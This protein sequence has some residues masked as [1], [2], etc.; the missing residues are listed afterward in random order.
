M[1]E[2]SEFI[3]DKQ[4]PYTLVPKPFDVL[5]LRQGSLH[6]NA[7]KEV[8]KLIDGQDMYPTNSTK[9]KGGSGPFA[10]IS[11]NAINRVDKGAELLETL[12]M[13]LIAHTVSKMIQSNNILGFIFFG[14]SWQ[15]D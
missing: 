12:G 5:Y 8:G 3:I 13:I 10:S 2:K 7:M 6:K 14:K 1:A 15:K 11:N 9:Y 4:T